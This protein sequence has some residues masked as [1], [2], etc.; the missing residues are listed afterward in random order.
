[1]DHLGGHAGTK[2]RSKDTFWTTLGDI[3]ASKVDPR[4][5]LGALWEQFWRQ[6]STRVRRRN[7]ES[8]KV[9]QNLVEGRFWMPFWCNF[10]DMFLPKIFENS[11]RISK[12]ILG[13][14]LAAPGHP[15]RLKTLIFLKT[16]AQNARST[17]WRQTA[18]ES[19]FGSKNGAEMD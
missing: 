14:I 7:S 1:M 8:N 13:A 15:P 3:F 4:R 16:S 10:G 5:H 19:D 12:A 2:S 17:F 18:S 6:K 11:D 9:F